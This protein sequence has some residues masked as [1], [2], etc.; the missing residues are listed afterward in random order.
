MGLQLTVEPTVE[1]LTTAEA[2]LHLKVDDATD[3]TLI[4]AIIAAVRQQ[5][6]QKTGR[7]FLGQTWKLT[8]D[9]FPSAIELTRVPILAVASVK[10]YDRDGAQQTLAGASYTVDATSE[11]AWVVPAYGYAWPETRCDINV[12]EVIWTAG[13]HATDPLLVPASIKQWM[14]LMIGAVYENR[15]AFAAGA[16]A[17]LPFVNRLLDRYTV[18]RL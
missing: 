9:R 7:A 6:E 5:A 12:V 17:E 3:D 13:Y 4:A 2:K 8:L 1:P 10:Y 16:I 15:E 14:L 18:P 11:P